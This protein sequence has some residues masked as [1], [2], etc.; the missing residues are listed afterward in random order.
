MAATAMCSHGSRTPPA[1]T[2][3]SSSMRPRARTMRTRSP[4]V[5]DTPGRR[6]RRAVERHACAGRRRGRCP[7]RHRSCGV[8][9]RGVHK[10]DRCDRR[11]WRRVLAI[12]VPSGVDATG[13]AARAVH[14]D[15]T[16]ECLL[17]KAVLRTGLARECAGASRARRSA[18]RPPSRARCPRPIS[19]AWTRCGSGCP[20]VA[21]RQSTRATTAASPASAATTAA[22]APSCSVPKLRCAAARVSCASTRA[23]HTGAHCSRAPAGGDGP[24]EDDVVDSEWVDVVVIG[25]GLGQGKWGFSHLHQL[26]DAKRPCVLDAM[27]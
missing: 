6:P 17:P 24:G 8:A 12:D 26:L 18:C 16:V 25:P 13:V 7:V 4:H 3:A 23:T 2:C 1:A 5:R 22:A 11:T 10:A 27:P 20:H 9:G 15:A 21:A 14:A 19:L